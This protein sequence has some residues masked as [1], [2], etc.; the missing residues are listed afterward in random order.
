M[1]LP[2]ISVLDGLG[3]P[4]T[5]NRLAGGR[6]AAA[7]SASVVLS[8]EDIAA[9]NAMPALGQSTRVY[10]DANSILQAVGI[11]STVALA[12]P[13][14]GV[15]REIRVNTTAR[16][17]IR[18]GTA[19]IGAAAPTSGSIPFDPGSETIQLAAFV[20]HFRVIRDAVDGVLN[21]TPVA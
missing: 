2:T 17:Y 6:Q 18:F 13:T 11:A 19:A 9:L 16:C 15:T 3:V 4:Q 10:S 21:L 12:I 20:T 5:V 1:A 7:D 8:V 14:L